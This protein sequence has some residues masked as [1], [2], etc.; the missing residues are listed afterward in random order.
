MAS[1][2]P[3]T[4]RFRLGI[5]F[6]SREMPALWP[7]AVA[8]EVADFLP[9]NLARRGS[10]KKTGVDGDVEIVFVRDLTGGFKPPDARA[11]AVRITVIRQRDHHAHSR[12]AQIDFDQDPGDRTGQCESF[13]PVRYIGIAISRGLNGRG[14]RVGT[15]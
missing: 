3:Q 10:C 2:F 5:Q 8:D 12:I 1:L 6:A 7:R 4:R 11:I 15:V 14:H 9:G 13:Y